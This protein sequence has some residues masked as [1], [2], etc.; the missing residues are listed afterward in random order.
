M[1]AAHA[2]SPPISAASMIYNSGT[3]GAVWAIGGAIFKAKAW[4][5]GVE[6]EA[7]TLRYVQ[8]HFPSIPTPEI[9]YDWVDKRT[10]RSFL[11]LRP[12]EGQTLQQAWPVLS[13]PQRQRIAAEVAGICATLT[14]QTSDI[15]ATASGRYGIQ[16]NYL[17]PE[18]PDDAPSWRPIPFPPLTAKQAGVYIPSLMDTDALGAAFQF[19]HADLSPTNIMVS[20]TD[21][22]V[23]S[24][25]DWESAAFY[26]RVWIATK[27]RVSYG[28]ILE[29]N[30]DDN[31]WAW[32][33]V[34]LEA[35]EKYNFYPNVQGFRALKEKQKEASVCKLAGDP[36]RWYYPTC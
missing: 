32:T 10:A 15:L 14:A 11:V 27:A 20:P 17:M 5:E 13:V 19:C 21:G 26:P 23:T 1:V 29:D 9:I 8:K 34:L 18:R 4:V 35:L 22:T 12:A 7:S 25:L 2:P 33:S 24:I 3:S 6:T 16:D 28:F 36:P 30:V 31:V